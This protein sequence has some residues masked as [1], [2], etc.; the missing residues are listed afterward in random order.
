MKIPFP[1]FPKLDK[2][3]AY[4]MGFDCGAKGATLK[5][6]CF[7]IFSSPENTKEWERGKHD[8]EMLRKES[9]ERRRGI[10]VGNKKNCGKKIASWRN[11]YGK[12]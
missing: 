1:P 10:F 4:K 6:C 12:F 9:K 5:N 11:K 8:A 3:H 7:S 2:K